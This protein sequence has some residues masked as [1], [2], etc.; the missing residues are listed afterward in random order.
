[1]IKNGTFMTLAIFIILI[2]GKINQNV[3]LWSF[4]YILCASATRKALSARAVDSTTPSRV[5]IQLAQSGIPSRDLEFPLCAGGPI[6]S[7][8]PACSLLACPV[9]FRFAIE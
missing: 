3:H 8:R 1:M 7:P 4:Q 6:S 2:K 5:V 9:A